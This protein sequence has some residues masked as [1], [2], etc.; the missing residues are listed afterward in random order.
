MNTNNS[1][2]V[3]QIVNQ[4]NQALKAIEALRR[5]TVIRCLEAQAKKGVQ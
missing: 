1:Q 3:D 2:T 4:V 5:E